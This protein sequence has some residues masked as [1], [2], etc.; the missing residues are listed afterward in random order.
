MRLTG[1]PAKQPMAGIGPKRT[2]ELRPDGLPTPT[3][4]EFR[5]AA[6]QFSTGVTIVTAGTGQTIRGMTA[7]SFASVSLDP[8]LIL[9]SI[10]RD[11][12]MY[13]TVVGSSGFGVSVLAAHQ[14][15]IARS[16]ADPARPAGRR[17]FADVDWWP[18][19]TTG[20]PVVN[21]ALAWF[22][23]IVERTVPTGDHTLILGQVLHLGHVPDGEPLVFFAGRYCGVAPAY[24]RLTAAL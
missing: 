23:C 22:D 13:Q 1:P 8:L 20:S 16:F 15:H 12:A 18:A 10:R 24:Q 11:S 3:T 9:V 21:D 19:P 14:I 5:D 6:G 7:N 17:Q 4:R 2:Y